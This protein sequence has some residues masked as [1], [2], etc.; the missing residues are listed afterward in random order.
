M[1]CMEH[2]CPECDFWTSNNERYY[3]CPECGTRCVSTWDEIE[4]EK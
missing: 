1:A 4:D 3:I 2:C